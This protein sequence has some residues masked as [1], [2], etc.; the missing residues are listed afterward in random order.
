MKTIPILAI[1]SAMAA[2]FFAWWSVVVVA[3]L[4]GLLA[5]PKN[6]AAAYGIGFAGV[7]L[8]WSTYVLFLNFQNQGLLA[9]KIAQILQVPSSAQLLA[10]TIFIGSLVG[11][12]G[13]MTGAL[14]RQIFN[15]YKEAKA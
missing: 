10:L 9:G 12:M 6:A 13:C 14:L 2:Y 3:A 15:K 1:L 5:N 4:V 7:G 8:A 11:G